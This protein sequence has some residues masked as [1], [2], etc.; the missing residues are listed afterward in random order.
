MHA[1]RSG[2]RDLIFVV[3]LASNLWCSAS[4]GCTVDGKAP[5]SVQAEIDSGEIEV[6]SA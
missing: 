6:P 5:T 3:W 1:S 4:I 2:W